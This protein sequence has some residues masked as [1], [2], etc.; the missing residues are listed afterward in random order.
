MSESDDFD[1]DIN[2]L[3]GGFSWADAWQTVF[4]TF[5]CIALAFS[6]LFYFCIVKVM[7]KN[8][9]LTHSVIYIFI[10]YTFVTLL[11]DIGLIL[12]QFMSNFGYQFHSTG[13]CQFVTFVTLGNRLLQAYG[14]LLLLYI[15]LVIMLLKSKKV[16]NFVTKTM[17]LPILALILLFLELI[18]ALPPAMNIKGSSHGKYC[19]YIGTFSTRRTTN[20]L[21][22]V[23]L[24]YFAPLALAIG[25]VIKIVLRLRQPNRSS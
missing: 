13:I 23:I 15:S 18:F 16:E 10:V 7:A 24:P 17:A 8:S 20:W 4:F 9:S 25:P 3:H 11:V 6:L 1:Q 19:H 21:F 5:D 12:E 2:D 22:Q 14:V